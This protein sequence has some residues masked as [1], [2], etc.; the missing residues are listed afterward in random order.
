MYFFYCYCY[1]VPIYSLA[2]GDGANIKFLTRLS[3][4]NFA[5]LPA[6]QIYEANDTPAQLNDF[7]AEISTPLMT[8]VSFDF[9]PELVNI[10]ILFTLQ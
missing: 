4:E 5:T 1:R 3:A 9:P 10:N 2:F 6:K 7:Y 8:N